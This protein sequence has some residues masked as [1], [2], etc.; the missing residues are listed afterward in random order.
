MI[1]YRNGLNLHEDS[2]IYRDRERAFNLS[3]SSPRRYPSGPGNGPGKPPGRWHPRKGR[4]VQLSSYK[5]RIDIGIADV[6]EA[7]PGLLY[8]LDLDFAKVVRKP[9]VVS[10]REILEINIEIG[11]PFILFVH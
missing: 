10:I 8:A 2:V 5:V 1:N 3:F 6:M 7:L 9:Q 4:P 11:F